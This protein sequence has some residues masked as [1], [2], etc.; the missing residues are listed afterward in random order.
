MKQIIKHFT[1]DDLYK[2]SMCCAVIE[3]YPR[4][5]VKYEFVDRDDTVYPA[6][7][8]DLLNE[9]IGYLEHLEITEEEIAFMK[10][11]CAYIPQWFYPYL[12]G[13]RYKREWLKAWQD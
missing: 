1:D 13:F 7:F 4:A 8:A 9:Q 10:R 12:K 11:R 6:G 2:F 3:N 5:Q